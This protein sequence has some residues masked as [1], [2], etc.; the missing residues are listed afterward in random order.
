M[1]NQ[2]KLWTMDSD[3]GMPSFYNKVK[4]FQD[5]TYASLRLRLEE[6]AAIDFVF[7]FW[8]NEQRCRIR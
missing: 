7:D 5:E 3:F 4:V 1:A 8:D 2:V 6:K